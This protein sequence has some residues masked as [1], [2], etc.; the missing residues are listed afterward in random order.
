MKKTE[1]EAQKKVTIDSR[2]KGL[3]NQQKELSR[4]FDKIQ[5]AIEVLEDIKREDNEKTD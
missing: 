5:G 4:L 3:K 2:I 1:K